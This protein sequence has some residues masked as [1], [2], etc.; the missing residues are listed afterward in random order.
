VAFFKV[1]PHQRLIAVFLTSYVEGIK[2]FLFFGLFSCWF[3]KKMM[4]ISGYE[5]WGRRLT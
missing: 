3:I 1:H 4:R 5:N 2:F